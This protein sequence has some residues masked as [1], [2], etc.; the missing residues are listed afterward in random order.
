MITIHLDHFLTVCS[1]KTLPLFLLFCDRRKYFNMK[2]ILSSKGKPP[3]D[4]IYIHGAEIVP[5][6][7]QKFCDTDNLDTLPIYSFSS[8]LLCLPAGT[9]DGAANLQSFPSQEESH[10][11]LTSFHSTED[12]SLRYNKFTFYFYF[13]NNSYFL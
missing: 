5:I 1:T 12:P 4:H 3:D 7:C 9:P 8:G 13:Q 11:E 6:N 2:L 10:T